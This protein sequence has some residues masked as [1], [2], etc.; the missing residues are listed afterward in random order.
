MV[1]NVDV[2]ALTNLGKVGYGGL[3]RNFEENF[4]FAFYGSVGFPISCMQ[5]FML[6]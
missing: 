6:L 2:C 4:Q 3:V 1:F 5:K